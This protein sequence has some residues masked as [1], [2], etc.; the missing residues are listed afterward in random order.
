M[1]LDLIVA[2]HLVRGLVRALLLT[3]LFASFLGAFGHNWV[4][5]PKYKSWAY[6]S[7]DTI[8]FSSD[9]W[10]REHNLQHHMYTN[11]PW[12]NHFHGTDPF[13]VTDPTV[14]RHWF[15]KY[16]SPYTNMIFLCF[17]LHANY[18]AHS[19]ELLNGREVLSPWKVCL[20]LQFTLMIYRWGWV[21]GL[22]LQ[23]CMNALL[24]MYYFTIA[25]MNHN[26]EQ[27][28]DVKARNASKDWAEAQLH[29]SA[30]WAVGSSFLSAGRY[31]WL[32][33]HTVHHLFPLV[34][35]SHHPAV[36]A[37]LMKTCEEFGVKYQAGDVVRLYK[38][39]VRSFA[40]PLSLMQEVL[41][42]GGG[43]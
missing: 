26:A 7:L 25:L 19:V 31:L 28:H 10:F 21:Y 18:I 32:N 43:L 3:G 29:S 20:P 38:E 37:I 14:E 1:A 17:G 4:H 23:L 13:L 12:D 36:Q 24:G 27:C 8:G 39:M 34:D 11:T 16:V 2:R 6:L 33:Y 5:Q 41:V 22:A 42:Y 30:D 9:G 40:S 15:Q 35:F